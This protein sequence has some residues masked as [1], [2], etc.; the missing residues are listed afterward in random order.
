MKTGVNHPQSIDLISLHAASSDTMIALC[1]SQVLPD[2][3][4]P[5]WIHLLPAGDLRTGDGRGPYRVA[6]AADLIAASIHSANDRLVLDENHST[7]LA[8]PKGEPAPARGWIVDLQSRADGIWGKVEWTGA[9]R[10]LMADKAYRGVS[11]VIAH[12]KDGTVTAILRA[13][14]VN[15]PNLKGLTTLHQETDMTLLQKLLQALNLETTTSED[16]LV[17]AVTTLHS[18]Q[19]EAKVSLHAQIAPIALAVGLAENAD[20]T[21]ILGAVTGLKTGGATDVVVALQSQLSEVTTSLN[22]LRDSTAKKDATAFVDAAIAGRKVG[23]AP[24]RDHYITMH[25][26]DPARVEKEIGAM[27]ALNAS[28]TSLVPPSDKSG[29][30]GLTAEDN[31]IIALMG[32]DPA[33]YAKNKT[34]IETAL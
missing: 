19:K 29:T 17:A 30:P 2:G 14:L 21:A 22:T 12:S 6:A 31:Q 13:S 7:D 11:P 9:G 27:P 8:A 32:H 33:E 5:E 4:A 20:A 26:A 16:A 23:V 3:D 34:A 25:M 18:A 1:A 10:A 15:R 24:L 28:S